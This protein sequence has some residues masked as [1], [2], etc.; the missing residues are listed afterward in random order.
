M[1]VP[2]QALVAP[3]RGGCERKPRLSSFDA[4]YY[5]CA[6]RSVKDLVGR[7]SAEQQATLPGVRQPFA[8]WSPLSRPGMM[9]VFEALIT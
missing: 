2:V 9:R 6:V 1:C 3:S 5:I 4:T 7:S 8:P